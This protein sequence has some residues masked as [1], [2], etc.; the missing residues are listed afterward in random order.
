MGPIVVAMVVGVLLFGTRDVHADPVAVTSGTLYGDTGG[1]PIFTLHVGPDTFS[2]GFLDFRTPP[3]SVLSCLPPGEAGSLNCAIGDVV[4]LALSVPSSAPAGGS[5]RIGGVEYEHIAYRMM[6]EFTT[7]D[8]AI[9]LALVPTSP[10]LFSGRLQVYRDSALAQLLYD[11][12]LTGRGTATA[13]LF[14][15]DFGELN[16]FD[17]RHDFTPVP[18]PASVLLLGPGSLGTYFA[19]RGKWRNRAKSAAS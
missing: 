1:P 14:R 15:G 6:W 9:P 12:S 4:S 5:A 2:G 19:S 18:E 17:F 11:A 13:S 10:F 8:I 3:N 16:W 7:P